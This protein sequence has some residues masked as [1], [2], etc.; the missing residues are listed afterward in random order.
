MDVLKLGWE[1]VKTEK[2]KTLRVFLSYNYL[3]VPLFLPVVKISTYGYIFFLPSSFRPLLTSSMLIRSFHNLFVPRSCTSAFLPLS[4]PTPAPSGTLYL[5][6]L[7]II[8]YYMCN[9]QLYVT[10]KL[11]LYI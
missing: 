2:L 6:T 8:I 10:C 4:C 11:L 7:K 3:T 9:L 1:R 5:L